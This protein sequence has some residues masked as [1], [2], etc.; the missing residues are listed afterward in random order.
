MR[1]LLVAV[2][3]LGVLS[4]GFGDGVRTFISV[5]TVNNGERFGKWASVDMCPENYYAVGFSIRVE[6]SQ[7]LLD[8]TA[9][10]GIRLHCSKGELGNH[11]EYTVESHSGFFG[12][13]SE[14]QYCSSG[15]L[16][17]FQ[18]RVEPYGGVTH[19][20]TAVN[21]I[22]FRCSDNLQLDGPGASG[23]KYGTW[24]EECYHGGIC[25]IQTKMEG[26]RYLSDDTTLNDVRLFCCDK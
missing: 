12:K 25:G 14:P 20:D 1:S 8:D 10:N 9:L 19:D 5:L 22:T 16:A 4:S 21:N 2:V 11:D 6:S 3:I 24:S 18:L 23:G 7:G 13:W 26:R 17:A 15:M